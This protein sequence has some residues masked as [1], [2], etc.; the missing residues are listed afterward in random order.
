MSERR[1]T[2]DQPAALERGAERMQ[3]V[4]IHGLGRSAWEMDP[5]VTV[6]GLPGGPVRGPTEPVST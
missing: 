3:G 6:W 5:I 1:G 2:T 4:S